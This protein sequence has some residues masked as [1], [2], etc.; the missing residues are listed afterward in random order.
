MLRMKKNKE[1]IN[2]P[3]TL[4][5]SFTLAALMNKTGAD[6]LLKDK[7]IKF[8]NSYSLGKTSTYT[9]KET[10]V[11]LEYIRQIQ[12]RE[13]WYDEFRWVDLDLA[14][15]DLTLEVTKS[16]SLVFEDLL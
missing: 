11:I 4:T 14:F 10:L 16:A 7:L 9:Q 5:H 15:E 13:N 8:Y 12:Y 3:W 6:S 2:N 1:T